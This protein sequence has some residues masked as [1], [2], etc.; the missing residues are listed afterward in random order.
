MYDAFLYIV[1][2]DGVDTASYYPYQGQV[3]G[4]SEKTNTL[5]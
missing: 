1:A 5:N 3:S 4:V 2:N